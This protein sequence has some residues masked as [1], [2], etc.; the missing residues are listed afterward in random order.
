[1]P[2]STKAR[3]LMRRTAAALA[4]GLFVSGL[5]LALYILQP[6][7]LRG[8]DDSVYDILLTTRTPVPISEVPIIVD[9]DESSLRRYGQWPW[10]RYLTARLIDTLAESGAASVGLDIL[11]SE[12]DRS[13]PE[14]L[15]NLL[16]Q[17][18][19]VGLDLS[20]LSP[21]QRDN[22]LRLEQ[23]LART[24][25]VL[26]VFMQFTGKLDP[27]AAL[28]TP[29]G[30]A[31]QTPPGAPE[32]RDT[33]IRAATA[34][35]PL[36]RFN[37]VAPVGAINVAPNNDGVVREIPLLYRLGDNIYANLSLRALMAGLDI[38]TLVLRSGPQGL[39]E[40]RVGNLRIP[41]TPQGLMRV[42]FKGPHGVYPY[43]SA[44]DVL[45]GRIA[46]EH[47]EGKVIF[48]GTSAAGL[49]DIRATPFDNVYPGVEVHA[50]TVDAIIN[51]DHIVTPAFTPG[52]QALVIMLAGTAAA[53]IFNFTRAAV[54]TP[55]CLFMIGATL[56]TSVYLFGQGQF[57]SPLY[58][59]L[60]I[61]A[62]GL[63]I[64]PLRF[65]HE[66]KQRRHLRQAFSRYVSPEVVA[67]IADRE[68]DIFAGEEREVTVLFTDVRG[69]TGLSE[70][71]APQQVVALL[72]RY[73]TP[74][75]ACVRN[76]SGTLDK[77]IGDAV[78][79]FWN[80]PLDVPEH[81]RLAVGA[82]LNMQRILKELNNDLEAEFGVRLRIGAGLHSG[83]VY[84]GNMGS[85]DL[86]D[87][88]CIGDTVN[89]ASRLE[90]LCPKYGMETVVSQDV[91]A[92]CGDAYYFRR[93]DR[94]RVKGKSLAVDI[95]T[96]H[97]HD[98]AAAHAD[99]FLQAE[100]AIALYMQGNFAA[101]LRLLESLREKE[102]ESTLLYNLYT[103]RCITLS[104][105][106]PAHWDGIW[107]F[108]SK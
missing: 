3:A 26:G 92:R 20:Q 64:L 71:L 72:N 12:P 47:F 54:Y 66:E 102:T 18:F 53:L 39:T 107:T 82:A 90:A 84:V 83:P 89:L 67:R 51:S 44:A 49:Q 76:S 57:I 105:T 93:L 35:L 55:L 48:I 108:N 46:K 65:A 61:L 17:N 70:K 6:A 41:V 33:V 91:A 100:T 79:A 99:E 8:L 75:T 1:M 30:L 52:L 87:Y 2:L 40:I 56:S 104:A 73:F 50:T 68:G 59:M 4:T 29:T 16:H 74:M 60:T 19:G 43:Y 25:T 88:T 62:Q 58:V 69:F 97:E 31:E 77:F 45:E 24:P 37:K 5:M 38:K 36:A 32:P 80:A 81:P 63:C 22:D 98:Y 85:E 94:I 34:L 9:I 103:E 101:A 7:F 23:T 106:P 42:P 13:S 11:L 21:E 78:M 28:P 27:S 14:L 10:S 95:F 96:A 86:L 15:S